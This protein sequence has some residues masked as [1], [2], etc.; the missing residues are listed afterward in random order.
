MVF[1]TKVSV[2]FAP[3]ATI[4]RNKLGVTKPSGTAAFITASSASV[5]ST[6]ALPQPGGQARLFAARVPKPQKQDRHSGERQRVHSDQHANH[7]LNL[8]RGDMPRR[9]QAHRYNDAAGSRDQRE[10]TQAIVC[11]ASNFRGQSESGQSAVAPGAEPEQR[12]AQ[13]PEKLTGQL[14]RSTAASVAQ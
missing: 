1:V 4:C 12:G 13:C 11:H 10:P 2:T 3:G 9:V 6:R 5:Y 14:R 7:R 8:S